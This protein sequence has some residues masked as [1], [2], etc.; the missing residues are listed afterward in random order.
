M[1]GQRGI[2]I[3]GAAPGRG[4]SC[5]I[6]KTMKE[7]LKIVKNI[8]ILNNPSKDD[9][10]LIACLHLLFP[11]CKIQVHSK[12]TERSGDVQVAI[13]SGIA[14]KGGKANGKHLDR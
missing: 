5:N 12:Q 4:I 7:R 10:M 1:A 3:G 8:V 14:A 6:F 9:G 13:G 11:E 2:A